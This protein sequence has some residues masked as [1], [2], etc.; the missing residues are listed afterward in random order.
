MMAKVGKSEE[1]GHADALGLVLDKIALCIGLVQHV[2]DM[3]RVQNEANVHLRKPCL[4]QGK[5]VRL[6]PVSA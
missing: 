4:Q 2:R 6:H 1:V 3:Q 5:P